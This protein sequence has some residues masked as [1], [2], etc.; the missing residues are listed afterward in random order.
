MGHFDIAL[1]VLRGL[2]STETRLDV[3]ECPGARHGWQVGCLSQ[4]MAIKMERRVRMWNL[5]R[6]GR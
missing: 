4:Y 6:H 2:T 1:G 5:E 3:L